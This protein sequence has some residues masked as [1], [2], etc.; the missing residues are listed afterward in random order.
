[1]AQQNNSYA[2]WGI[3][4]LI[5]IAMLWGLAKL[6]TNG[7]VGTNN[8]TGTI[9]DGTLSTP[10][11]SGDH[12]KGS[13]DAPAML[14]E[15]SDFQCPACRSAAPIVKQVSD[16]LGDQLAVVYRHFPLR[17]IHPHAQL[18]GQAAYAAGKQGKF[19]EMHDE[20]FAT[21]SAWT[22]TKDAEQFFVNLAIELELDETVF[23]T[24]MNSSAAK[25]KVNADYTSGNTSGVR[26]TPTFFLN[27]KQ[28]DGIG[29][30]ETLKSLILSEIG[31]AESTTE[32]NS[33]ENENSNGTTE[34][35]TPKVKSAS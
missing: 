8:G 30:P 14:V 1:M 5:V 4:V 19:W 33:D 17:Q 7:N 21:Q 15:Y 12:I 23:R 13:I 9:T 10:V 2:I 16:E 20:L 27:G 24:D 22:N 34:P 28:L 26:G 31:S 25:D 11:T 6:G 3:F 29:S 35:V 32:T 18:A